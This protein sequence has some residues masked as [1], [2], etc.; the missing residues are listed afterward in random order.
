[1]DLALHL[2]VIWRFKYLVALGLLVACALSVLA[3]A[4]V[5]LKGGKPQLRYRTAEIWGGTAKLLITQSGLPWGRLSL[6]TTDTGGQEQSKSSTRVFADPSR[7]SSLAPFYAQLANSDAMQRYFPPGAVRVNPVVDTS[8]PYASVLPILQFTG[9]ATS[10]NRADLLARKSA[11]L[12]KA[13]VVK[14]QQGAAIPESQR[15]QL[16]T[17]SSPLPPQLIQGRKKSLAI[18]VFATILI[19][20]LGLAFILENLRPEVRSIGRP[21]EDDMA[22]VNERIVAARAQRSA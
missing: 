1:L 13:Y 14:Q 20:T 12:F 18:V 19:A 3:V 17:L 9:L 11:A 22:V 4:R 15:V 2:R 6:P 21:G 10:P 7:L 8:T 5:D 16:E